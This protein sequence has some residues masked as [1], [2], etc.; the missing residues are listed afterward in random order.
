[1][2]H[3]PFVDTP[4]MKHVFAIGQGSDGIPNFNIADAHR[5]FVGVGGGIGFGVGEDGDCEKRLFVDAGG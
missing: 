5:A 1:M 2:T 3:E 4:N